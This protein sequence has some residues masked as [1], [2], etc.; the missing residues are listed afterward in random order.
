MYLPLSLIL[1]GIHLLTLELQIYSYIKF[2]ISQHE[3][4]IG[5]KIN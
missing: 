2:K 3:R 4:K 1:L 5:K